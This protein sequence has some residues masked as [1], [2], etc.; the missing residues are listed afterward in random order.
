MSSRS[1][2]AN[3]D[4]C[5]LASGSVVGCLMKKVLKKLKN[6]CFFFCLFVSPHEMKEE[7]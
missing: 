6:D 5:S 2:Y 7:I 3:Q 4:G 1:S